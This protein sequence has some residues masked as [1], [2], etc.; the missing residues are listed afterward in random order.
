MVRSASRRR[1]LGAAPILA[2]GLARG[3][4][5]CARGGRTA[6]A[7]GARLGRRPPLRR[8]A[9]GG[10]RASRCGARAWR[11][12]FAA[13]ARLR[14]GARRATAPRRAGRGLALPA[15]L[16]RRDAAGEPLD[17]GRAGPDVLE[18]LELLDRLADAR[19]GVGDL[20]DELRA[21]ASACR[22]RPRW[23]PGTCARRRCGPPRRR[24]RRRSPSLPFFFL[25]FFGMAATLFSGACPSC[26]RTRT[27]PS[28]C[29]CPATPAAR[30]GSRS[31]CSTRPRCSTTTAG[32]G[33]T[34]ARPPTA[35]R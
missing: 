16:E 9:L 19:G 34:P 24:P 27:S 5:A 11:R 15:D 6:C 4:A 29:C 17:L 32:C 23:W 14:G 21:C 18:D 1:R 28:E 8:V 13:V 7:A 10:G 2:R 26:A 22:P 30:C 31:S 25:S 20:V 35:R 12:R 33:A 3:R